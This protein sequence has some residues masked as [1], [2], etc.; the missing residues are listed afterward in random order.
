MFELVRRHPV[1]LT[2]YMLVFGGLLAGLAWG[3]GDALM[4]AYR[5][6]D[7]GRPRGHVPLTYAPGLVESVAGMIKYLADGGR[8]DGTLLA[9]TSWP[10]ILR[11]LFSLTLVAA[12]CLIIPLFARRRVASYAIG[13]G[14]VVALSLWIYV[15]AALGAMHGSADGGGAVVGLVFLLTMLFVPLFTLSCV[16]FAI[17]ESSTNGTRGETSQSDGSQSQ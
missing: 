15:V 8:L 4:G 6:V 11:Q 5:F 10:A 17:A 7:P 9:G 1:F 16:L 2:I 14:G 12:A 3:L 13:V